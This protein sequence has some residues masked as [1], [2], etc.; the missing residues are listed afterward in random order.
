MCRSLTPRLLPARLTRR[1]NGLALSLL[2]ASGNR[3]S[4]FVGAVSQVA[5]AL[6]MVIVAEGIETKAQAT[7][8]RDLGC[9][10][11]QGFLFGRP[12]AADGVRISGKPEGGWPGRGAGTTRSRSP[13]A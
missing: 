9:R 12:A 1:A 11:G 13:S 7:A 10:Y 4:H 2:S 5:V 6:S 8:L 3:N